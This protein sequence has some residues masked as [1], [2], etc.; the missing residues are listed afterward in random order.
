MFRNRLFNVFVALVLILVVALT[1]REA[2]A[3]AG[4]ISQAGA[5]A[6]LSS[7]RCLTLPS[8]MSIQTVYVQEKGMWVASSGGHP[9]GV[10]GGLMD[11]LRTYPT[12]SR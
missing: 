1:A 4:I 9:T 5:S 8:Q 10:D 6:D 2:F 3:T 12:C 11:L 7:A